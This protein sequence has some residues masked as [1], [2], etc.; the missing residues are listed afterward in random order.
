MMLSNGAATHPHSAHVKR[1]RS[2]NSGGGGGSVSVP[3]HLINWAPNDDA[4]RDSC[5]NSHAV[6]TRFLRVKMGPKGPKSPRT[7][8]R[9]LHEG[10]RNHDGVVFYFISLSIK[11]A[12]LPNYS[13]M[14]VGREQTPPILKRHLRS[15]TSASHD[16]T[17]SVSQHHNVGK[18]RKGPTTKVFYTEN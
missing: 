18:T 13:V 17:N 14:C 9:F 11:A 5:L 6:K 15:P 16:G 2:G 4:F 10:H 1:P 12:T 7:G 8:P 3:R